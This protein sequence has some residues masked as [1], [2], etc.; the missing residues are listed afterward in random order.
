MGLFHT[1]M[2][3]NNFASFCIQVRHVLHIKRCLFSNPGWIC[4]PAVRIFCFTSRKVLLG[5]GN[6]AASQFILSPPIGVSK[7]PSYT[8]RPIFHYFLRKDERRPRMTRRKEKA[9]EPEFSVSA[10]ALSS[11]KSSVG[12]PN[13]NPNPKG[14]E[15]FEGSGSESD[16][17]V[18]I[19]IRKDPKANFYVVKQVQ[20]GKL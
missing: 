19:R 7:M 15:R 4:F 10:N 6:I 16:Q 18:R 1:G 11:F 14:S 17:T 2:K 12:E 20:K 9:M 5:A 13:P 8:R 3:K